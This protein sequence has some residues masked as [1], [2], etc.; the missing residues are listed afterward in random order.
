MPTTVQVKVNT[1]G[2]T[3]RG[4]IN[5]VEL[6]GYD[7]TN[8]RG[9]KKLFFETKKDGSLTRNK[10]IADTLNQDD[11]IEVTMDDT[12]YKNVQSIKKIAQPA[13]GDVP[14]QGDG[15]G[16]APSGSGGGGSD[17]MSK[18]EW[19]AKDAKKELGVA[20]SV[21]LKT[22]VT[23]CSADS[24]KVTKAKMEQIEKMAD[25]FTAYLLSGD[26]SGVPRIPAD[27]PADKQPGD[28]QGIDDGRSPGTEPDAPTPSDDDIP[29]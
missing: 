7:H 2:S 8:R 28:E 29:F 23:A 1:V 14:S 17:K 15:G 9:F 10:E 3:V 6:T 24:S 19:A 27:V 21:A 12:S 5:M 16:S 25:R 13:G 18:A 22:A 4:N 11:W 26:F 20:R